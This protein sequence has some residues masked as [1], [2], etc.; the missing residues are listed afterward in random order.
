MFQELLPMLI[1]R[2]WCTENSIS[3][4]SASNNLSGSILTA[5]KVVM[6]KVRFVHL[7]RKVMRQR[8]KM[9]LSTSIIL[10]LVLNHGRCTRLCINIVRIRTT[11]TFSSASN[12][13]TC[14]MIGKSTLK[15]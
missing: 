5:L 1:N 3:P 6:M 8:D 10:S 4:K 13:K 7:I 14:K 2:I 15:L 11:N 12:L 9:S